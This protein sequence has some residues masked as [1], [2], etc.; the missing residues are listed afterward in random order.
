MTGVSAPSIK[1][2]V[3][4][5][6]ALKRRAKGTGNWNAFSFDD[7]LRIAL[8][9]EL[10]RVGL[11][12]SSV[13]SLFD[14]IEEPR[15]GVNKGWAWLRSPEAVATGA[16]LVLLPGDPSGPNPATG[17]AYVTT[18]ADAVRWLRSHR[19]CVVIDI[20]PLIARLEAATAD[21]VSV[22]GGGSQQVRND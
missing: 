6:R 12:V 14:A 20:N 5:V 8:A 1:G 22:R 11:K 17:H 2:I 4:G 9:K 13:S 7:A 3:R 16:V 19:T 10:L 18:A 15:A 21:R